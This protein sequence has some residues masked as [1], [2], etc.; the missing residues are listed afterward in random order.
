[1]DRDAATTNNVSTAGEVQE[2]SQSVKEQ[3]SRIAVWLLVVAFVVLHV[4]GHFTDFTV[5]ASF[6]PVLQ[7]IHTKFFLPENMISY[8]YM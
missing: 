4:Q 3:H 8:K 6:M 7:N 2:E 5:E 1:M